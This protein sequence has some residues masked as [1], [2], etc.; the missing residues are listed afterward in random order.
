MIPLWLSAPR[1][2]SLELFLQHQMEL[3][4]LENCS[5]CIPDFIE[6]INKRNTTQLRLIREKK[7][8]KKFAPKHSQLVLGDAKLLRKGLQFVCTK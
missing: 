6:L 1:Q 2:R 5:Y 7:S 4:R 3:Q 8:K